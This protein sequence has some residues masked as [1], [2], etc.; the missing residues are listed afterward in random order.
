ML[1]SL[2]Q[3]LKFATII[4]ELAAIRHLGPSR[5]PYHANS[6]RHVLAAHFRNLIDREAV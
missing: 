1:D 3:G 2:A 4:N 6:I 5:Q